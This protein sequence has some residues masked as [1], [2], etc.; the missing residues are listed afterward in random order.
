MPHVEAHRVISVQRMKL[1]LRAAPV[2]QPAVQVMAI[3]NPNRNPQ[4]VVRLVEQEISNT[5]SFLPDGL[6]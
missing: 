2:V 4:P 1:L 3:P 5:S 6:I